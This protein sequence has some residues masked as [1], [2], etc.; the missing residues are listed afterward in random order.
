MNRRLEREIIV[1]ALYSIEIADND[2]YDTIHYIFEQ[3]KITHRVTDY[4]VESIKGVLNNKD[5][6]DEIIETNLYNYKL[7]RLSF[8]DLAIIRFATYELIFCQELNYTIIINEAIELTRKYSDIGDNKAC[9]FNNKLLDNIKNY[10][11]L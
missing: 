2:V 1:L 4:I 6:I 11:K 5:K 7:N 3:K 10:L 8:V 9:A